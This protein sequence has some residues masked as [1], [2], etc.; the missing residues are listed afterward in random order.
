MLVST[1][2]PWALLLHLILPLPLPLL[3]L[4][5]LSG[6]VTVP[7]IWRCSAGFWL[8]LQLDAPEGMAVHGSRLY[9]VD[10]AHHRVVA[11]DTGTLEKVGQ[12]PPASWHRVSQG[13]SIYHVF[14]LSEKRTLK[15][16][17]RRKTN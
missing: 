3:L 14:G 11:F 16:K 9:V 6:S 2:P 13:L 5:A 8:A 10:T 17:G 15:Q 4:P 12:Y 1:S 7:L